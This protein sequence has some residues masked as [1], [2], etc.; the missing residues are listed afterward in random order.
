MMWF[1]TFYMFSP[2]CW[3]KEVTFLSRLSVPRSCLQLQ[4]PAVSGGVGALVSI[5]IFCLWNRYGNTGCWVT[6]PLLFHSD[7]LSFL[8]CVRSLY[9]FCLSRTVFHLLWIT[10][11][12]FI[13]YKNK[14]CSHN[15]EQNC[16]HG[17]CRVTIPTVLLLIYEIINPFHLGFP[18]KTQENCKQ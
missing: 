18:V 1:L 9:S 2:T 6:F 12:C 5:F 16:G 14:L 8:V 11:I 3:S 4:K 15:C 10:V 7:F 17:A 13:Y